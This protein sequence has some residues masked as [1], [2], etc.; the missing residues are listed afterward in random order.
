MFLMVPPVV[1]T[2]LLY[3]VTS[4]VYLIVSVGAKRSGKPLGRTLWLTVGS[5]TVVCL[6]SL[7]G[8]GYF[9]MGRRAHIKSIFSH[10]MVRDIKMRVHQIAVSGGRG[11]EGELT[12]RDLPSVVSQSP[13]RFP[14]YAWF[15]Y[16][17][18][19]QKVRVWLDWGGALIA[20]HG[21]LITD[22]VMPFGGY[23]TH[24]ED[25][26]GNTVETYSQKYYPWVEGSY[27][28]IDEN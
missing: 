27:I 22:E 3:L 19:T 2:F 5:F 16:E 21:I 24:S 17:P 23:P 13:W 12:P 28:V 6:P 20:H 18:S 1:P 8:D 14:G 15:F 25:E 10:E 26:N 7:V 4:V 11:N 9:E